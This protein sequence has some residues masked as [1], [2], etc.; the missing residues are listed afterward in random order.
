M[1]PGKVTVTSFLDLSEHVVSAVL[2]STLTITT[3]PAALYGPMFEIVPLR[4]VPVFEVIDTLSVV[5]V[6]IIV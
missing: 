4:E 5:F 3:I 6:A 2:R 1:P